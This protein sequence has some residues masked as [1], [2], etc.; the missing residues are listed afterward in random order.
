MGAFTEPGK[1]ALEQTGR[2]PGGFQGTWPWQMAS[3]WVGCLSQME[4]VHLSPHFPRPGSPVPH[5][6]GHLGTPFKLKAM[7]G[8]QCPPTFPGTAPSLAQEQP[9]AIPGTRSWPGQDSRDP[10]PS[11]PLEMRNWALIPLQPRSCSSLGPRASPGCSSRAS[12]PRVWHFFGFAAQGQS[13]I[14]RGRE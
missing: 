14:Y 3:G 13:D 9:W 7:A 2:V 12:S 5:R 8:L 11:V 4:K 6:R 1:K 10:L